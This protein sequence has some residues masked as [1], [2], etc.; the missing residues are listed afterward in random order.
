MTFFDYILSAVKQKLGAENL[1]LEIPK[2][3]SFGDFST[4]IAMLGAK[5][6]RKNPREV[7][8]SLLP[9][10]QELPFA[11][12][13]EIAGPGFINIKIKDDLIIQYAHDDG[14]EKT[15]RPLTICLDYGSYNVAKALHVGHLRGS[16]VGDTFYRIARHLGHKPISYNHMGDWGKPMALVI[17]WIIKKFPRDWN[18][19]DFKIDEDEFNGYYPAAS[20]HAAENPDFMAQVLQIKKD[21]QDGNAEYGALYDK[22]M[23][24]SLAQMDEVVK[25]LGILPFDRNLGEM[26]AA[27]YLPEVEKILRKK[28]LLTPSDGATIINLKTESDTAPMPPLMFYDSRGADTYDSTDIATIYYRKITDAPDKIIYFTDYRQQLHFKQVFR[29]ADMAGIFPLDGLEFPYYG[30]INGADGKPFKTR[31][32]NVATLSDV[33]DSVDEA[34]RARGQGLPD[35]TIKMIALAAL[36]FN[37]LMHDVKSDY[38]FDPAAVVNFE[39]RTGPYILYTAVRLNS[40]LKKSAFAAKDLKITNISDSFERDLL[41]KILDFPRTVRAAFE[42]R[43]PDILANYTYDLCQLANG[44][45]H[46]CKISDDAN[47]TA[48]AK[49]AADALAVCINLMGMEVPEEM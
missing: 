36:K 47:R 21:F 20:A 27:K 3:K 8:A 7:A 17:A 41:L 25:R 45:Y 43:A 29:A 34:A 24:I 2:E 14:V 16:I 38:I 4:N 26:N 49:K 6:E 33:I 22:F 32:G 19:P 46:N 9:K 39:G 44:F 30:G 37:D 23:T 12:S 40:A 31:G 1:A 18:K 5:A 15:S 13:V 10:I 11:E 28:N 48:I 35:K 42:K